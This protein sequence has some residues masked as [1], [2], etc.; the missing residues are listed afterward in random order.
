[1]TSRPPKSVPLLVTV[2]AKN[3]YT[4]EGL[5]VYLQGAGLFTTTT[6]A[7]DRVLEVT[8]S[9]AAA[10]IVFPDEYEI[11]VAR[12]ALAR[13]K[14]DRAETLRVIVTNEPR[15]FEEADVEPPPVTAP[16]VLAK[17]AWAWTILDAVRIRLDALSTAAGR[18]A[19][20]D[21]SRRGRP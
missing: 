7:L 17:P 13:L 14:S 4:L 15:R 10:V 18:G 3:A 11:G 20:T 19:S 16:L 6:G 1:M 5:K 9:A 8:P 12:H 21:G 2:V